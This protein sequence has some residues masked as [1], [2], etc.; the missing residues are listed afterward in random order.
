MYDNLSTQQ[1]YVL[2]A[3][4]AALG[5]ASNEYVTE[6]MLVFGVVPAGFA[7]VEAPGVDCTVLS[8]VRGGSQF[9]N[10]ADVGG[11]YNGQW[12]QAVTRWTTSVYGKPAAAT[13]PKTGY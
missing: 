2:E 3:S 9:T 13:L 4:P 10:T 7:Q 8:S 5:L 12:I 6:F 1:N 11:V